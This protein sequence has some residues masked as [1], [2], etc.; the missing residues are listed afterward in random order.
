[1]G[2][3]VTFTLRSGSGEGHQHFLYKLPPGAPRARLCLSGHYDLMSDGYAVMPPS[4]TVGPYA[5]LKYDPEMLPA[6]PPA[7]ALELLAL[8]IEGRTPATE[9]SVPG[10]AVLG[11]N[12]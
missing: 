7:W 12:G 3:P 9:L 10:D 4:T 11:E 2:L 5:W 1:R 6:D 8:Q